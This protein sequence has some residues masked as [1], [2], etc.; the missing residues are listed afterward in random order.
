MTK[1]VQPEIPGITNEP[2]DISVR[3]RLAWN[4]DLTVAARNKTA[5]PGT[6]WS[7]QWGWRGVQYTV[8]VGSR[9]FSKVGEQ[10]P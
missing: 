1:A 5:K 7:W 4:A 9:K 2:S 3:A 10:L 6:K 8:R